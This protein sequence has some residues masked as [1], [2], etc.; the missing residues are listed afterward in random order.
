VVKQALISGGEA[1]GSL[2]PVPFGREIG[3]FLGA[4]LSKLI[5]SGDYVSNQLVKTNSLLMPQSL[6]KDNSNH[7]T[8]R[9]QH[10]EYIGDLV[11]SSTSFNTQ[12][13]NINPADSTVFPWL[14]NLASNFEQY[15][16]HGLAFEYVSSTSEYYSAGAMGTLMMGAQYD[17]NSPLYASKRIMENSDEV[18]SFRPDKCA[19]YGVECKKQALNKYTTR[20]SNLVP[21]P[22]TDYVRFVV[23][24]QT[25][26]TAVLGE[27]WAVYDIELTRP[28]ITNIAT[29]PVDAFAHYQQAVSDI[30]WSTVGATIFSPVSTLGLTVLVSQTTSKVL[31]FSISGAAVNDVYKIDLFFNQITAG[32]IG[33]HTVQAGSYVGCSAVTAL[34]STASFVDTP[35]ATT[36]GGSYTGLT[37]FVQSSATSFSFS[38]T[39][40]NGTVSGRT[41]LWVTRITNPGTAISTL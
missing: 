25:P 4:K 2:A 10:R 40:A 37:F 27:L 15:H 24:Y 32:A 11:S 35:D 3:G 19:V 26:I 17:L 16:I 22:F 39:N 23:G 1:A 41:D 30:S 29:S 8:I 18:I 38:L 36:T 13:F 21:T 31:N 9:V 33:V 5:G 6:S 7:Q 28:I 20:E 34:S 12:V 14:S